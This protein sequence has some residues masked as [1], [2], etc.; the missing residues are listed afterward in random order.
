MKRN[1]TLMEAGARLG[2]SPSTL[3]WQIRNG[4]LR[5]RK[6]GW[7]WTVTEREVERYA[8]QHRRVVTDGVEPEEAA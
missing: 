5:A 2:L 3:R 1:I 6:I 4:S 8:A 7:A